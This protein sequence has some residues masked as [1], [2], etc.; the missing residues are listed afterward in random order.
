MRTRPLPILLGLTAA[1]ALPACA[2]DRPAAGR[3]PAIEAGPLRAFVGR[4][5]RVHR[6]AAPPAPGAGLAG[7]SM[8]ADTAGCALSRANA[9]ADPAELA[10]ELAARDA[11]GDFLRR[12]PWWDGAVECPG[13]ADAPESFT[14]ITGYA[15]QPLSAAG[16]QAW[17]RVVYREVGEVRRA[18]EDQARYL[19]FAPRERADTFHLVRTPYGW[20]VRHPQQPLE[21]LASAAARRHGL[22]AAERA[23]LERAPPAAPSA[24]LPPKP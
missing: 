2:R 19:P 13:H 20:R 12:S 8:S 11:G 5:P 1:L 21:V 6:G 24:V 14:V 10:R 9:H 22:P 23:A 3:D 15:L 4:M 17:V 7:A 18:D 16:D